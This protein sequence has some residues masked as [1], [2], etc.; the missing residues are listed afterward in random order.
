MLYYT[1]RDRVEALDELGLTEEEIQSRTQEIWA[2]F[3]EAL[4]EEYLDERLNDE[5]AGRIYGYVYQEAH[6][7]GWSEIENHYIGVA[8]LLQGIFQSG[9]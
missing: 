2:E 4:R 7:G 9:E 5:Q 3:P 6:S 8:E 1:F